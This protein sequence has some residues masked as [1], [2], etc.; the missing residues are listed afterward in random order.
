MLT[1]SFVPSAA[2]PSPMECFSKKRGG[3]GVK[4]V[5]LKTFLT[6]VGCATKELLVT[7]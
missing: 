6:V 1:I 2:L 5:I 3:L 7:S 4:T